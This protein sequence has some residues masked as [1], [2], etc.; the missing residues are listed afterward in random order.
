MI[1][2]SADSAKMPEHKPH[3]P[4]ATEHHRQLNSVL[5]HQFSTSHHKQFIKYSTTLVH[6]LPCSFACSAYCA[7]ETM[8]LDRLSQHSCTQGTFSSTKDFDRYF[9]ELWDSEW[10][11]RVT[12]AIIISY[13]ML[14]YC[15]KFLSTNSWCPCSLDLITASQCAVSTAAAATSLLLSYK[16]SVGNKHQ[17]SLEQNKL[18]QSFFSKA[19][20][21]KIIHKIFKHKSL[22]HRKEKKGLIPMA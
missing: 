15:F 7:I 19:E 8:P 16:P 21:S 5:T 20:R 1:I 14:L 10:V 3:L 6:L 2:S 11:E 18:H 22:N 13:D 9:H 17:Q 4:W 12:A